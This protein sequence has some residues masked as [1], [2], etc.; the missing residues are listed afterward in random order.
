MIVNKTQ[1]DPYFLHIDEPCHEDWSE[2]TPVEQGR[3]CASCKKTVFDFT[4]ASDNEITSHL[5]K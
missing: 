2:M 3:F 4:T 5:K 1:M